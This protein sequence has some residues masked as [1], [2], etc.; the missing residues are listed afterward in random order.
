M[1]ENLNLWE[2]VEKTDPQYTKQF[3]GNG[4]GGTSINSA[5]LV[6]KAT[7]QWGMIGFGWGY[8]IVEERLDTGAAIY[9]KG[10][11]I[12]GNVITHTIR[13][14]LWVK[15][16]KEIG[17]VEH[18]GH[19][20]YI[21]YSQNKNYWITDQEAC[22]K[23][24]TDALKKCLSMFGFSADIFL[25]LYEDGSYVAEVEAQSAIN[26]S[27]NKEDEALKQKQEYADLLDKNIEMIEKA[28]NLNMLEAVYKSIIRRA[29][30]R[31][32]EAGIKKVSA[33]TEKRKSELK[34]EKNVKAV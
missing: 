11:E 6:K 9:N 17:K 7:E 12:I 33:A 8:E 5:Y 28:V 18:Y 25:G 24:L 22:K 23:S 14:S 31:N 32:D 19:T 20:P 26:K 1:S 15:K 27:D 10:G 29:K 34:G 30:R 3:N 2:A 4:F 21:Y 16:G 13:L